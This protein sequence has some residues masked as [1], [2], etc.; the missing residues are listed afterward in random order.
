[1]FD[2]YV[3]TKS[4]GTGLGLAI[5]KKII[6]EHGGTVDVGASHLGGASFR[7]RLPSLTSATARA[8]FDSIPS[9]QPQETTADLS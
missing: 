7:I 9:S 2:P 8:L 5:V 4:D 1:V 6:V 3:T